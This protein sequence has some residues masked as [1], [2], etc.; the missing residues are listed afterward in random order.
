[1]RLFLLSIILFYSVPSFS[2]T[3]Y[4]NLMQA[5]E[6]T[7]QGR[8]VKV[9]LEKTAAKAKKQFKSMEIKLQKEEADLKKEAPLLSEQARMQKIQTLQQ[10][11]FNFQKEAKNKDVELQKLQNQLMNPVIERLK[12]VTGEI[13]KKESYSIVENIGND[14]LWVSPKLDLTQKV[15]KAFNK[16]Y[17]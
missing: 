16:K 5:F 10:K 11:I 4:V 9:R 8:R 3:A 15:S 17:K 12:K 14:V 2:Q 6:N 7:K 1:M 13:A